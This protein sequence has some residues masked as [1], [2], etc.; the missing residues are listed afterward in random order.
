MLSEVSSEQTA[1]SFTE[2]ERRSQ[3][4]DYPSTEK[5]TRLF[6]VTRTAECS[7]RTADSVA[8]WRHGGRLAA[9]GEAERH[10][11][12][13]DETFDLHLETKPLCQTEG[14]RRTSR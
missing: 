7:H 14:H 2:S 9:P 3:C 6:P 13:T 11:A 5:Q 4:S 8:G 12:L 1:V 10:G